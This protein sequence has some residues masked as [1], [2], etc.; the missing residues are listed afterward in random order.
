MDEKK[1][2]QFRKVPE[3]M[4]QDIISFTI[5]A[6][7]VVRRRRFALSIITVGAL[8]SLTTAFILPKSWTSEA[9]ILPSGQTSRMGKLSSALNLMNF[10][11]DMDVSPNSSVFFPVIL[12]SKTLRDRLLISQIDTG[13]GM[14]TVLSLLG[15]EDKDEGLRSLERMTA[16]LS[17]EK[18]GIIRLRVTSRDPALSFAIAKKYVNL[19]REFNRERHRSRTSADLEFIEDELDFTAGELHDSEN[20]LTG[21]EKKNRNFTTSTDPGILLEHQRLISNLE[22]KQEIYIDLLKQKELADIEKK[23]DTAVLHILDDPELPLIKSGP[24]RKLIALAGGILSI[25][26]GISVPVVTEVSPGA[27]I[28]SFISG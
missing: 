13:D 12:S 4:G 28:R 16:I 17:D 18:T 23:K 22:M 1:E 10:N 20:R 21:F 6:G 5:L 3:T 24:P 9:V 27:F 11:I 15:V 25:F 7:A 26:I 19:L 14:T 2:I 8:L